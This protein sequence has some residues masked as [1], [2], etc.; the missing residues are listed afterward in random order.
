MTVIPAAGPYEAW[1]N[2]PEP[3]GN[4]V[5]VRVFW[6]RAPLE[7]DAVVQ[8]QRATAAQMLALIDEWRLDPD[9]PWL[10]AA[11]RLAGAGLLPI[12]PAYDPASNLAEYRRLLPHYAFRIE[13]GLG[14]AWNFSAHSP[15]AVERSLRWISEILYPEIL[16]FVPAP[17]SPAELPEPQL[18]NP[19]PEIIAAPPR[20]QPH[21]LSPSEQKLA[22]SIRSDSAFASLFHFNAMVPVSPVVRPCVD[23]LWPEGKLVVEIDDSSHWRKEKY[24]ADRQRDFDLLAAGYLVLR[25]TAEEVLFDTPKAVEKIRICVNLRGNR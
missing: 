20:G 23:L 8:L 25:I 21:P 12:A 10:T 7:Q 15:T 4:C 3:P 18:N 2:H 24:A 9:R 14:E 19:E 6:R 11:R 5:R 22:S 1:L 17:N 13:M 16:I